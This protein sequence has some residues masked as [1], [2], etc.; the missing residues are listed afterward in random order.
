MIR[1]FNGFL[2]GSNLINVVSM[3][4]FDWITGNDFD[5]DIQENEISIKGLPSGNLPAGIGYVIIPLGVDLELYIEDC[6]RSGRIS[7]YGGLGYSNMHQVPVDREVLQRIKFPDKVGEHGSPVVWVN[8][9]KYNSPVI[10]SCLKHDDELHVLQEFQK[11]ITRI[12][13]KG[14]GVDLD[15][16]PKG[17][18]GPKMTLS[19]NCSE[20][21]KSASLWVK[22]NGKGDDNEFI[23]DVDGQ[24]VINATDK[25]IA[26]GQNTV[27][28]AVAPIDGNVRARV[29]MNSKAD[30]DDEI[31]D[32]L[33]YEDE[34][35][36]SVKVNSER[37]QIKAED[38][39]RIV[40]GE[41]DTAE[42]LVKGDT[43][44]EKLESILDAINQITVPT[45]FGPS[46]T[47]INAASFVEIKNG[48]SDI[49][50]ELTNTD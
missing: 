23:L 5:E 16:N 48:L 15:M 29:V 25:I 49:L 26:I 13:E 35:K 6:Y 47:P 43:T 50:S 32:R 30:G 11:R 4:S 31:V 14:N 46:G 28:V 22:V 3:I 20:K 42:P 40:F 21:S 44:V 18:G 7:M 2:I 38:S 1:F 10:I 19:V 12:D 27:E 17:A 24:A 45:A 9:P 34:Y 36:N 8:I 41:D 33:L 37:I 39:S